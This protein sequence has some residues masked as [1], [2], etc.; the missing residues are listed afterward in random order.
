MI[1]TRRKIFL[2]CAILPASLEAFSAECFSSKSSVTLAASLKTSSGRS[3]S[4]A[5]CKPR[6]DWML[7]YAQICVRIWLEP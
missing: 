6:E 4:F 7:A 5:S 3:A 1:I 2:L